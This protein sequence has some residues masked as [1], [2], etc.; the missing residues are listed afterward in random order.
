M[1]NND[2]WSG[3]YYKKHSDPQLQG[4]LAALEKYV[5]RGDEAV[6]DIG[7]GDGKVTAEIAKRVPRGTVLGIDI[8]PSMIETSKQC[9]STVANLSFQCVD[10]AQFKAD[11]KFDLIVSFFAF[12]YI[13]KQQE[14]LKNLYAML[15]Q[16]G[17]LIIKA[18]AGDQAEVAE[19]FNQDY[20]QKQFP[21]KAD[22]TWHGSTTG[23]QY[24]QMLV[25][26]GFKNVN[27]RTELVSRFFDAESLLAW[28]MAWV[29]YVTGFAG[30]KALE[31]GRALVANI[32]KNNTKDGKIEM[33]SP[34]ATIE[35]DKS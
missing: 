8:S 34:L 30:D 32:A 20:W 4:A 5:F 31:F 11:K 19:V 15:K 17:K 14:V 28:A 12:H 13:E 16:G 23:E 7:C 29:P 9:F 3:D 26:C 33:K 2:A 21:V 27:V 1:Q 6:L 22:E 24:R 35:A 10:A 25:A 18:S